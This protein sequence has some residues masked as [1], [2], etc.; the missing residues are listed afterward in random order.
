MILRS[1]SCSQYYDALFTLYIII[2]LLL[3]G[4]LHH[5]QLFA[6]IGDDFQQWSFSLIFF[7][8]FHAMEK[9]E[10]MC[11]NTTSSLSPT[12]RR[13]LEATNT[14]LLSSMTTDLIKAE[15]KLFNI[16]EGIIKLFHLPLVSFANHKEFAENMLSAYKSLEVFLFIIFLKIVKLAICCRKCKFN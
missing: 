15:A 1:I 2:F 6:V 8:C 4:N 11:R 9:E 7:S 10:L 12:R 5:R 14:K 3:P 16:C 13:R